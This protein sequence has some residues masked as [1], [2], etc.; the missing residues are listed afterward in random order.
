MESTTPPLT[1]A[2][3]TVYA[4]RSYAYDGEL[5]TQFNRREMIRDPY[6]TADYRADY[7]QRRIMRRENLLRISPPS[8]LSDTTHDDKILALRRQRRR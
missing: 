8:M 4:A 7:R 1:F 6:I 3:V 5:I 2:N